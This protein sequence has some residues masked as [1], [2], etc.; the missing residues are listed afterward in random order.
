M[1]CVVPISAPSASQ[2]LMLDTLSSLT[3][4]HLGCSH[5]QVLMKDQLPSQQN[6]NWWLPLRRIGTPTKV[7]KGLP[8]ISSGT[9]HFSGFVP[10]LISLLSGSCGHKTPWEAEVKVGSI[11]NEWEDTITIIPI[12]KDCENRSLDPCYPKHISN[13]TRIKSPGTFCNLS[14]MCHPDQDYIRKQQSSLPSQPMVPLVFKQW[15]ISDVSMI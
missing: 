2:L 4:S 7:I 10:I 6:T 14:L 3:P 11:T 12:V 8:H 13:T 5:P 1:A 9:E 15:C